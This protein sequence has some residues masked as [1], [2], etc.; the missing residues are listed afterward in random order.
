[1][2]STSLNP[3]KILIFFFFFGSTNDT[4]I[5]MAVPHEYSQTLK[6]REEFKHLLII[7]WVVGIVSVRSRF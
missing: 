4:E 7:C 2:T 5:L 3:L 6:R 1:M